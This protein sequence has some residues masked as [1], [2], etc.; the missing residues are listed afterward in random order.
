MASNL[1]ESNLTELLR[2]AVD[3]ISGDIWIVDPTHRTVTAV[4]DVIAGS[5]T[6]TPP[7]R[8][9]ADEQALKTTFDD[10]LVASRTADLIDTDRLSVRT[11]ADKT[12]NSLL[13]ADGEVFAIVTTGEGVA[14]LT[15]ED[16]AFVESTTATCEERWE[17]ADSFSL[18]TPP[19]SEVR[20]TL[21]AEIG[22]DIRRDFDTVLDALDTARGNDNGLDEVTISL[23][24]AARNNVLLYD[25]SKWG[26]DVGIASKATFS[27][28]KTQLED[29]GLI[30]TE[31]V[32]IDVGR[33]RL[34]L[35]LADEQLASAEIGEFAEIA[36]ERS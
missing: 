31:K 2:T 10:F 34:R 35:Q 30:T 24:V 14:A 5:E 33:P 22:D 9:L 29:T 8:M 27:R 25:I 32:P 20:D 12:A 1:L 6:E 15:A 26:E 16:E 11:L 36:V 23:L 3:R 18:R 17:A 13:V 4:V 19:I 28:T 21:G 7:V